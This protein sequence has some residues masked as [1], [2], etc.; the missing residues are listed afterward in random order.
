MFALLLERATL[1]PPAGAAVLSV[2]VHADVPGAL[3]VAGEQV[4][5]PGCTGTVRAMEDVCET[6]E[7]EAVTVTL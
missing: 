7:R 4:S 1:T 2:T 3:T 6:P 5:E